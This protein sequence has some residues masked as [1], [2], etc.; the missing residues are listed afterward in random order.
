MD[1]ERRIRKCRKLIAGI[2]ADVNRMSVC[3]KEQRERIDEL[4]R[5][6]RWLKFRRNVERGEE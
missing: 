6:I 5:S 2:E 1:I 3:T 4:E